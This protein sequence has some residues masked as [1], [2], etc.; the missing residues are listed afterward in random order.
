MVRSNRLSERQSSRRNRLVQEF[1]HC[2]Y[3]FHAR[4]L[5]EVAAGLFNDLLRTTNR[6][7]AS[8]SICNKFKLICAGGFHLATG[9][10]SQIATTTAILPWRTIHNP[11]EGLAES[12]FGF[13]SER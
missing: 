5:G 12:A 13:I 6:P 7:T 2:H 3:G 9:K 8:C 1:L 10:G 11:F 4:T